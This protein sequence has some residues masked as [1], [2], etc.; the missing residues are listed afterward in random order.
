MC[1]SIEVSVYIYTM[2]VFTS[3]WINGLQTLLS[4]DLGSFSTAL[5]CFLF[6]FPNSAQYLVLGAV[7]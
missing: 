7:L 2:Q 1:P 4:F 6:F 5:L 3:L